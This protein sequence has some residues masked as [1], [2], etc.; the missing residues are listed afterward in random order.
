MLSSL[1]HFDEQDCEINLQNEN[2]DLIQ[3]Q[4]NGFQDLNIIIMNPN[5]AYPLA[6][7]MRES[8]EWVITSYDF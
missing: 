6:K 5:L 1:F 4:L 3:Y 2:S 7:Y 8:D